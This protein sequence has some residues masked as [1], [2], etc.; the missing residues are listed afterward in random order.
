VKIAV[1]CG[2][3]AAMCGWLFAGRAERAR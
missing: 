3:F 1:A 2:L